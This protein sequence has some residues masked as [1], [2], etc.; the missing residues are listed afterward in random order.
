MASCKGNTQLSYILHV[1]L[2]LAR[3]RTT[4]E[5][6]DTHIKNMETGIRW[7][8]QFFFLV[9]CGAFF[10]TH[11]IWLVLCWLFPLYRC[12]YLP[13]LFYIEQRIN[14]SVLASDRWV[15]MYYLLYRYSSFVHLLCILICYS[16]F[17][18]LFS[19][20][21]S[22]FVWCNIICKYKNKTKNNKNYRHKFMRALRLQTIA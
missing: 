21:Q 5:T 6:T 4:R 19:S 7:I 3:V 13:L 1:D 11:F 2:V 14:F 8:L 18:W 20:T 22:D 17:Y 9:L 16:F 12:S 10:S 15:R